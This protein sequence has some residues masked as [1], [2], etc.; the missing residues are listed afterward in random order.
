MCSGWCG[1]VKSHAVPCRGFSVAEHLSNLL[2]SCS[3]SDVPDKAG[4][5]CGLDYLVRFRAPIKPSS[6][7][8]L[9][10]QEGSSTIAKG[11]RKDLCR[12][13]PLAPSYPLPCIAGRRLSSPFHWGEGGAVLEEGDVSQHGAVNCIATHFP[14]LQM[15]GG[16][17][18]LRHR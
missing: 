9:G 5:S 15:P 4:S 11:Q 14:A 8:A 13:T 2:P 7:A 16:I 12:K 3:W 6:F 10:P 17:K 1:G 18:P